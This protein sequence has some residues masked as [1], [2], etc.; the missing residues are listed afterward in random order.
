MDDV[1]VLMGWN[2][3]SEWIEAVYDSKEKANWNRDELTKWEEADC[4]MHKLKL[5]KGWFVR[6]YKINE[7]LD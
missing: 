2:F 5:D 6:S 1:W 4:N 3:N 7:Y